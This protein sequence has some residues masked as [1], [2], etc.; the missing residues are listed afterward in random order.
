MS[1]NPGVNGL[2]SN[3]EASDDYSDVNGIFDDTQSD[4][5]PDSDGDVSFGGDVDYRDADATVAGGFDCNADFYTIIGSGTSTQLFRIDRTTDPFTFDPIGNPTTIAGGFPNNFNLNGLGY[6]PV[7]NFM[8]AVVVASDGNAADP[9]HFLPFDIVRIDGSG[10]ITKGF[11][12]TGVS[13]TIVTGTFLRDGTYV[14]GTSNTLTRIDLGSGTVLGTVTVGGGVNIS[15]ISVNPQDATPDRVYFVDENGTDIVRW[16]NTVTG[17]LEGAV[18]NPTGTNLN[19]GSQFFDSFGDLYFRSNDDQGVYNIDMDATSA[20]YGVA[21]F[22]TTAPSGGFHDGASCILNI[23]VEKSVSSAT[24]A[25]GDVITYTYRIANPSNTAVVG[26][27]LDD[28]MAD[29]RTFV[30]GS[31]TD[32]LGGTANAYGGTNSLTITGLTVPANGISSIGVDVQIPATG[33]LGD[34]FNQ[35]TLSNLPTGGGTLNSDDP[36][37][38][39]LNDA[40]ILV[41]LLDTDGDLVADVND[42]DDDNDGILDTVEVGQDPNVDGDGDGVPFYLDDNDADD[43]VFNDDGLV[44]PGF[45]FD[46]D[47]VANHLDLDSDNDGIPDNIEAQSTTGYIAPD[48]VVDADGVDTAYTGGLTPV[49]TDGAADGADYLDIDSDCLLYTS[50]SPRDKRQS[51][52]PSSA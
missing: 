7:D 15:D 26:L 2:D 25:A 33:L 44:Q 17:V 48:G 5:F 29:A 24:I 14:I 31:L 34:V 37:T 52:M 4:N 12:L 42:L 18:A 1:N 43:T 30:S 27:D 49:N 45:D 16:A 10:T 36:T 8:Y 19:A 3:S 21:T 46:G 47:G 6:N 39:I 28:T 9:T 11:S 13:G 32:D 51:R 50:P 41:V 35:V 38:P 20:T 23:A 22:L 40:T